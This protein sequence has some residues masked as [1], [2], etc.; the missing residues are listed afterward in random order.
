MPIRWLNWRRACPASGARIFPPIAW[1]EPLDH[2]PALWLLL[3]ASHVVDVDIH[4]DIH[5]DMQV[6]IGLTSSG[7]A[8]PG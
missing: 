5:V 6:D 8:R 1:L 2:F 7:P 4:V 3:S